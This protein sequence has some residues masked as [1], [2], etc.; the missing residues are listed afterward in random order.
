MPVE[1]VA[2]L[3]TPIGMH[4]AMNDSMKGTELV[5]TD[6]GYVTA[7]SGRHRAK[8]SNWFLSHR[9][10]MATA[11]KTRVWMLS[12]ALVTH[13]RHRL[14]RQ[15]CFR[16]QAHPPGAAIALQRDGNMRE[17]RAW[18][19]ADDQPRRGPRSVRQNRHVDRREHWHT[20]QDNDLHHGRECRCRLSGAPNRLR[21]SMPTMPDTTST[22]M[23]RRHS[24][25]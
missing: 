16:A 19:E 15:P 22:A 3:T 23:D 8:P 21:P 17:I 6:A 20:H 12:G 13:M 4:G 10:R 25:R 14:R 2:R 24:G 7:P 18:I 9:G 5:L 1:S 11:A